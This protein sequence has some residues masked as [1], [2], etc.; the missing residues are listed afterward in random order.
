MVQ[1]PEVAGARIR[2]H[3]GPSNAREAAVGGANRRR[4]AH[5]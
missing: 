5:V 1:L 3:N 2:F 4:R